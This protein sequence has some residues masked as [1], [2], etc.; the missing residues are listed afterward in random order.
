MLPPINVPVRQE[1]TAYEKILYEQHIQRVKTMLPSI[2]NHTPRPHPFNTNRIKDRAVK[3]KKIE[4]ENVKI[5]T[6]IA[7]AVQ[8][9]SIDNHLSKHT[10]EVQDFKLLLSRKKRKLELEKIYNENQKLLYNI[11]NASPSICF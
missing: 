2:D 3:L 9:S 6:N 11:I 1:R 4:K 5:L 7:F 10:K 8:K